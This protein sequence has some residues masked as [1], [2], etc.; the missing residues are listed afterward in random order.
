[1]SALKSF[2]SSGHSVV[3]AASTSWN[4]TI[5]DAF[6]GP[7]YWA[8]YNP[9]GG[10][11]AASALVLDTHQY[12]AFAPFNNLA[13]DEILEN[14]CNISYLLKQPTNASGIPP[15]LV[16]EW[17]LETGQAPN[18][19]ASTQPNAD[20]QAKR[21]WLRLLFEAQLAAYEPRGPG[22][23]NA[24]WYFWSWKQ[25]YPIDTWSYLFGVQE[26]WIPSDVGN[27][28]Q[29]VFPVLDIGCVDAGFNYTAPKHPGRSGARQSRHGGL[30]WAG[31][32]VALLT[33]VA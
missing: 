24:G 27:L 14:I 2:Y 15:T 4:T 23:A 32:I 13:H 28:S 30:V 17:S 22:G 5:H 21:T 3:Q 19:S 18:T 7:A 1:M 8:H 11:G 29:R 20:N 6:Y 33:L 10:T 9:S 12:Y 25:E 16:G 31:L 26:G